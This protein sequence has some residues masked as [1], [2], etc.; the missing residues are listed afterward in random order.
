MAN[1]LML[2]MGMMMDDVSIC[3]L[4][5][6]ILLPVAT[7][8]GIDPY[9][10]GAIVGVNAGLANLTPPVAPLLY[11]GAAIG[12][13]PVNKTFRTVIWYVLFGHLPV[14]LLVTYIP[15]ISLWLPNLWGGM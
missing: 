14:L 12:D 13:V 1:V 3:L 15:A 11:F 7:A 10:F 9:H 4:V 2:F 5:A 8:Y 6:I